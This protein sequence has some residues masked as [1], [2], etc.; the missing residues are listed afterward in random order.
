MSGVAAAVPRCCT[1]GDV[2]RGGLAALPESVVSGLAEM[3]NDPVAQAPARNAFERAVRRELEA[4]RVHEAAAT[5]HG[6]VA[7][8]LEQR[9]V[10]CE[11]G[12]EHEASLRL[13]ELCRTRA[14]AALNRAEGAR[15]RL[16]DE[17]VELN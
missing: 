2:V 14:A 5:R 13:A 12:P 16:R 1:G 17:G 10:R 6:A 3:A 9:A 11:S 7:T 4:I 8:I 15:S